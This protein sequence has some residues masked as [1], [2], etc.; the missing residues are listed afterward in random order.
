MRGDR[1]FSWPWRTRTT[2]VWSTSS[3]SSP[4]RRLT[5]TSRCTRR[6]ICTTSPRRTRPRRAATVSRTSGPRVPE[7]DHLRHLGLALAGPAAPAVPAAPAARRCPPSP[8][9]RPVPPR[10]PPRA[11]RTG[12]ASPSPPRPAPRRSPVPFLPARPSPGV[13]SPGALV[14]GPRAASR[15]GRAQRRARPFPDRCARARIARRR[16]SRSSST[17]PW[18]RPSGDHGDLHQRVRRHQPGDLQRRQPARRAR[19]GA[20]TPRGERRRHRWRQADSRGGTTKRYIRKLLK[21]LPHR[22]KGHLAHRG[23]TAGYSRSAW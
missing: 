6:S 12:S 8:R 14:P 19:V 20:S 2:S 18:R 5:R 10:R 16:A 4:A 7:G 22:G 3:S 11:A 15:A 9:R 17:P 21:R 1:I 13:P 23:R